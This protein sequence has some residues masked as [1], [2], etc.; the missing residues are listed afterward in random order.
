MELVE[1]D[2]SKTTKIEM[3][4]PSAVVDDLLS[5]FKKNMDVFAKTHEDVLGIDRSVIERCLNIDPKKK[6][7]Q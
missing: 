4:L 6:P 5:F 3:N 2:T 1:G 7:I